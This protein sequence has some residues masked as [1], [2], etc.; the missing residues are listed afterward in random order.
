MKQ[1]ELETEVKFLVKDLPAVETRLRQLGGRILQAR[2][3][4]IN[5]RFDTPDRKLQ[6]AAQVLR[7]RRDTKAWVTYKGRGQEQ[8][9]IISRQEIEIEVDAFETTQHLLEALGFEVVFIYEKYR[10]VYALGESRVMLDELPYGSFVEIEG[11]PPGIRST[12][13]QLQLNWQAAIPASYHVLF[14]RTAQVL[15][16]PFRDL[17]FK[18]FTSRTVHAAELGIQAAD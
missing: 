15:K 9:G 4:E 18:N 14:E 13:E 17:T 5:L 16:L 10:T 6:R 12:A 3:Y 2:S 1:T 7:L 11:E 8:D